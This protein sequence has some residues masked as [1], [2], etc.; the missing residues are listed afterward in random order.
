MRLFR[1]VIRLL[2]VL[3]VLAFGVGRADATMV[4][5]IPDLVPLVK[6]LKP[7]VVNISTTQAPPQRPA[8]NAPYP[9]ELFKE[10]PLQD[11]FKRFLEPL[12]DQEQRSRSLGSGVII[13]ADGDILTN[14]HVI[15]EASQITVRLAD[16]REFQATVVGRDVKTD[17]ALIRIKTQEALPV[18]T[19]GDSDSLEVGSWVLAIG[20]PF[21]L[22]AT[23]TAGI[24]SAKGRI[25]GSGPY[26]NFIQTDAAINPGN[27]G[28][29]LF[30]LKG[31][32][33]GINTAI[34]SKTG[35]SM[36]I[37][38]A[39]PMNMANTIVT[40]L[41]SSGRV[42]RGWLG[43]RIQALTPEIASY[44]HLSDT[45]GALVASVEGGS[46]AAGAAIVPRDVILSFDGKPVKRMN[47]LPGIVANTPKGKRVEVELIR[48]GKPKT[49]TVVIGELDE[50]AEGVVVAATSAPT[51]GVEKIWGLV[52]QNLTGPIREELGVP[53]TLKGVVVSG[54][55]PGSPAS[56]AGIEE[57]DIL[58]EV[59]ATKV[60]AAREFR[61]AAGKVA[62]GE[63]I[64]ILVMRSGDPVFV[65][66]KTP[67]KGGPG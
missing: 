56:A 42:V 2:A 63:T 50:T 8:G 66:F 59:N 18:A 5:G 43:V 55:E 64:L 58:L 23:V 9:P 30:N 41:K 44:L 31:E 33:V 32:V 35:G 19:L 28:G 45:H 60:T 52:V 20:N 39:I 4:A 21:G 15:D 34:F 47:D 3:V 40:Q 11:F 37:G 17:L 46:P 13:S 12:P 7:V 26:D 49:V 54:V 38:F 61:Q 53:A 16:D 22:D 65:A 14:N 6:Q 48:E 25:I 1:G 29:P 57:G 62:P 36:G 27:S 10:A 67:V 51:D 24:V